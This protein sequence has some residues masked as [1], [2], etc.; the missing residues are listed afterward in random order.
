VQR[1]ANPSILE[2]E[3]KLR[4]VPEPL[5]TGGE[6]GMSYVGPRNGQTV[7]ELDPVLRLRL[8]TQI[9]RSLAEAHAQGVVHRD[10]RLDHVQVTEDGTVQLLE[11][12]PVPLGTED[13]TPPDDIH[14][15]GVLLGE[16]FDGVRRI[17]G[18]LRTLLG[19]MKASVPEERPTATEVLE[20]LR[21]IHEK[22]KSRRRTAIT[23]LRALIRNR[24]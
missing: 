24:F 2:G 16:L 10:I 21:W 15:F 23:L 1:L 7:A 17:D 11:L 5:A 4:M 20:L 12:D 9:A 3:K 18:D 8:A 14:A 6:P 13:R 19:R 22:P